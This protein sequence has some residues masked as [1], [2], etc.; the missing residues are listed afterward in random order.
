MTADFFQKQDV[1]W[2]VVSLVLL[3]LHCV[4]LAEAF[5]TCPT[6]TAQY[7]PV[8]ALRAAASSTA[9]SSSS[10]SSSL[11]PKRYIVQN[12]F[13]IRKG[14]EAAFEKR[15]ADRE[16]RLGNLPGFRFFC[17]L[18]K[19]ND[20]DTDSTANEPNYVSCTIWERYENFEA[21][22]KGDA[23]KEAHGG[24]TMRG[25]LSM[26]ASTAR[27][28]KGKPKPAFWHGL[29]PETT[30]SGTPPPDGEGWRRIVTDGSAT[31]PAD[32]FVAMN[33]FSVAAN[34]DAA[35]EAK[36]AQRESTL[37]HCPGFRGFLLLRRD[38]TS[39]SKPIDDGYTHSTFSVWDDKSSFDAW[40]EDS[41]QKKDT[42]TNRTTVENTNK[43]DNGGG[44]GGGPPKIYTKPPVP[45]FY[46]GILLLESKHGI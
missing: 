17:M 2:W 1:R 32:C 22:R 16:S 46:E 44:S 42:N 5:S 28:T 14:R 12:R 15:W 40:M 39:S 43:S 31:V 20:E 13:Q 36:F 10:S 38:T 11:I 34:M 33:R 35:F 24:G 3:L 23:F 25:V 4:G 45:T 27:N 26:L 29:L 9:T 8:I 6:T 21:W 37:Q 18:R 19:V 30:G 7:R 41:K